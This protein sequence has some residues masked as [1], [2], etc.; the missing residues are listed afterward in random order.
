MEKSGKRFLAAILAAA[1]FSFPA[2]T[3][4]AEEGAG[5][6]E[7]AGE[8]AQTGGI[9]DGTA[10]LTADDPEAEREKERQAGY[11]IEPDTN[12]LEGWP[13]GPAVYADSA[14]IM[15][16]NT[17]AVLY[18]KQADVKHYP[19]SITKLLTTLVALENSELTDEV[20]FSD[21]SISFMEPGDASI[22]M[23]SGEILSMEDALYGM[24]LASANEVSY[25][26][27]ENVGR[28]M[29]GDYD[30]FIQKMNDRAA[31]LGCANS[32]WMN[33]NGL[34]DT[35][36]YTTAHDMAVIASEVYQF[37]E[38]RQ[39]VQTLSYTIG[40]TNLVKED[41]VF[42]QNHKMLWPENSYYYEYCTGGKTGYT[43]QA[44]TT[45]VTMADNGDLQLAAVVL[46]DF[47]N[48]AYVDTRAMFDY[49]FDNF[50]KVMLSDQE[51]PEGIEAY[52]EMDSYVVLPTG[53]EFS[54]LD[55]KIEITD[56]Q[57]HTGTV[58][59]TYQG[60]NVGSADVVLTRDYVTA[61]TQGT[62]G[63][64]QV[65]ENNTEKDTFPFLAKL[66]IGIAVAAV[67]LFAVLFAVLKYRQIQRRRRRRAR[68]RRAG[69]TNQIQQSRNRQGPGAG[70]SGSRGTA[71]RRKR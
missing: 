26:V 61:Q 13:Q 50:E 15:E 42:Q 53:I 54:D 39:I 18:G 23:T 10:I 58:T 63:N 64:V 31:E 68:R 41:R 48:D 43:D 30:T 71:Q 33:A 36:H 4:V 67:I 8:T 69:R 27:A 66:F 16:M 51:K 11:E 57:K 24:L 9:K 12:G 25:A 29:G 34:H 22:G 19:A 62:D 56:A 55:S 47:G 14:I 49:A 70:T 38:F 45:L 1:L 21:D 5:A 52:T 46:Y 32:H 20:L 17:G 3:A 35:K 28:L 2:G 65:S 60:Q 37:E 7:E 40:P 44:R 59:Y 6:A